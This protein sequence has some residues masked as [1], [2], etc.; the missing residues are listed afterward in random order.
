MI[1][2][3]FAAIFAGLLIINF[4]FSDEDILHPTVI[5]HALTFAS[6]IVCAIASSSYGMQLHFNTFLVLLAG[7]LIFT[8]ANCAYGLRKS[9]KMGRL[10]EKERRELAQRRLVYI[11]LRNWWMVLFILFELV[12]AYYTAKYVKAVSAALYGDTDFQTAIGNYNHI[13]K[14]RGDDAR[15]L[16]VS[17]GAIYVFGWPIT[18]AVNV[19]LAS[20]AINNYYI[21]GKMKKLPVVSYIIMILMSLLTGSRSNAF[22]YFTAIVMNWLIIKRT[23]QGSY[24]KGNTKLL[25]RLLVG[26]IILVALFF[27]MKELLGRTKEF[28]WTEYIIA[29]FGGPII[30]L[31]IFLNSPIEYSE[32]FGRETFCYFYSVLGTLLNI[33]GLRYDL[34]LPYIT[35]EGRFL[36]NVYTMYYMFIKDFGYLGI[37][38]LTA[39]IAIFYNG[40]Y[41]KLMDFSKCKLVL[42]CSLFIY[43]YLTNALIMLLFSNRFYEDGLRKTSLYVYAAMALFWYVLRHIRLK[44]GS[45]TIF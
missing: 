28:V 21:T 18:I 2:I 44:F 25:A 17:A 30:N 12:V 8:I 7:C 41:S 26:T 1:P 23:K 11:P 20:V 22:R 14:N 35:Y 3:V 45:K 40:I 13:L 42:G 32:F 33:P 6:T 15:N 24:K 37:V 34:T 43:G 4:Y 19:V 36:G 5:F 16:R 31:D 9:R 10:E 29:Y 38:P 27:N 39:V